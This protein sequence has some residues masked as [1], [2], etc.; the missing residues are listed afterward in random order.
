MNWINVIGGFLILWLI[1]LTI[2]NSYAMIV[3]KTWGE[4]FY[5]LMWHILNF[6]IFWRLI[7]FM[8][9]ERE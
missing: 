3:I 7:G 2:A 4:F 8:K 1:I 9:E 6:F 5:Y